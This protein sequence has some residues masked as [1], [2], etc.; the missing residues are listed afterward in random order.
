MT[1]PRRSIRKG[2]RHRSRTYAL[3][4][5]RKTSDGQGECARQAGPAG[6]GEEHMTNNIR[7]LGAGAAFV[8]MTTAVPA[9]AQAPAAQAAAPQ[10]DFSKVEIK[11]TKLADNFYTLEGSGGT[12]GILTGPD[13]VFMV[14][15]E[16]AQLSDKIVAAIKQVSTAPIR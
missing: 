5:S 9:F 16:F 14:D 7:V 8:F 11:T 3:C 1:R 13:G 15:T 6:K 2:G 12:I 4:R 10:Q